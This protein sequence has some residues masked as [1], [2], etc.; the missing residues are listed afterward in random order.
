MIFYWMLI[1]GGLFGVLAGIITSRIRATALF[2]SGAVLLA[3]LGY[4]LAAGTWAARCWDCAATGDDTR[5]FLF[6]AGTL[7]YGLLVFTI[8]VAMLGAL[9]VAGLLRRRRA[10][11]AA[12]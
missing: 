8:A 7:F 4:V 1:G 11:E 3:Y 10:R 9:A 5:G 12:R 2:V 6:V